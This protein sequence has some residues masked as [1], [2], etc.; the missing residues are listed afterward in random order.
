M[1]ID[2]GGREIPAVRGLQR[3]VSEVLAG[4][5][6]EEFGGGNIARGIDMEL[7]GYADSAAD[8]GEG[9]RRNLGQDLIEHFA[10]SD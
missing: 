8:G 10:L 2:F 1:A 9:A 6:G 5:G 3:L 4:A 7:Y